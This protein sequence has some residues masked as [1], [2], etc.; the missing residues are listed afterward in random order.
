[1]KKELFII[2][3]VLLLDCLIFSAMSTNIRILPVKGEVKYS[4]SNSKA[5]YWMSV[6]KIKKI[7]RKFFLKTG[8]N[9]YAKLQYRKKYEIKVMPDTLIRVEGLIIFIFNGSSWFK[10]EKGSNGKFV[11]NTPTAIAGIRGT[12]FEIEVSNKGTTKLLVYSGEVEIKGID[13]S[14]K[15]QVTRNREISI[16]KG[17]VLNRPTEFRSVQREKMLWSRKKW[18]KMQTYQLRASMENKLNR[19][20]QTPNVDHNK[21][22]NKPDKK[23]N[24]NFNKNIPQKLEDGNIFKPGSHGLQIP[25]SDPHHFP[26]NHPG[27]PSQK[28][29][30]PGTFKPDFNSQHNIKL[31][32]NRPQYFPPNHPGNLPQ[33]PFLPDS[34]SQHGIQIPGSSSQSFTPNHPGTSSPR[35]D[36]PGSVHVVP[37]SNSTGLTPT[38]KPS[39]YNN[40]P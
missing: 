3:T 14:R 34:K 28:P 27:N 35:P 15:V 11:V 33:K 5:T 32:E 13:S 10:V 22:G 9:G 38:G 12:E 30:L 26:P 2:F 40:K 37:Q 17:S 29:N 6:S 8:K 23:G 36:L 24:I 16:R 7:S 25:G 31:P 20:E 1:M 21:S 39:I 18:E 19:R 4:Y